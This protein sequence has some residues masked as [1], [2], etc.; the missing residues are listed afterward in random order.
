MTQAVFPD[1][2]PNVTSGTQL[3]SDLNNFKASL[4]TQHS[5]PSAPVY[6]E[7]GTEW[8]DSATAGILTKKIYDGTQ[9]VSVY[10]LNTAAHILTY[11][12]NNPIAAFS[13][14]RSDNSADMLEL[15]RDINVESSGGIVFTQKND[16]DVK[17]TMAKIVME[18]ES[19]TNGAEF[20]AMS[21]QGM[22]AGTLTELF[23]VNN[24][25]MFADFLVGTGERALFTDENGVVSAKPFQSGSNL[26]LNGSADTGNIASYTATGLA[27]S[28]STISTELIDNN[29][30]FKAVSSSGSET[31]L[32][33]TITLKNGHIEHPM[34]VSLKYKC[35]SNWTIEMLDQLDNVL[36]SETIN[37]FTPVSNEANVKKIFAVIPNLT[38]TL[39]IRLTSSSAD[40]LLFDSLQMYS[41][42]SQDED[43]YF[44]RNI[45]NNQLSASTLFNLTTLKNKAYKVIAR[46]YRE[47]DINYAEAITEFYISFNQSDSTW[48][49]AKESINELESLET[50]ISFSISGN[51][52]QY[53]TSNISGSNYNG[54]INGKI[55]RIL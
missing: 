52:L 17:K 26:V 19:V 27:F 20:A 3:A 53:T 8:L 6:A 4:L 2:D 29:L 39:K 37:G 25:Q 16:A 15:Y 23:S 38:T 31:L 24:T 44:E 41:L 42:L 30:V 7:I 22:K 14:A 32:S 33:E 47:T 55:A 1:I 43:L 5:G 40:V 10:T 34:I 46:V 35:S 45:A 36:V 18:S 51:N 54:K 12:G 48:R 13:I 49:I 50:E 11:G 9:W 28:K 21:F